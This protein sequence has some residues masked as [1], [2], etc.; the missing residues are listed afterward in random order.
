[1]G[2]PTRSLGAALKD[3]ALGPGPKHARRTQ[4]LG[5]AARDNPAFVRHNARAGIT[6]QPHRAAASPSPPPPPSSTYPTHCPA[7]GLTLH[8]QLRHLDRHG[9]PK[10]V[11]LADGLQQ[12]VL[13]WCWAARIVVQGQHLGAVRRTRAW[14]PCNPQGLFPLPHLHTARLRWTKSPIP[15]PVPLPQ[16]P[17]PVPPAPPPAPPKWG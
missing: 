3:T 15:S 1:M 17:L 5:G 8:H 12:L 9:L 10:A 4:T 16:P 2:Q 6:P 14:F 7:R 11:A 13:S